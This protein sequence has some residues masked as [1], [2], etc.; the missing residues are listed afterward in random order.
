MK[1]SVIKKNNGLGFPSKTY[2]LQDEDTFVFNK[3]TLIQKPLQED[4]DIIEGGE[5]IIRET[6]N[7]IFTFHWFAIRKS[8]LIKLL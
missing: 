4:Y 5:V 1:K 6:E 2:L 3:Y 8:T 7:Y